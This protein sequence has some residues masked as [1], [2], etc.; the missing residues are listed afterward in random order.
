MQTQQ[1]TNSGKHPRKHYGK[2]GKRMEWDDKPD[3]VKPTEAYINSALGSSLG[4]KY[5]VSSHYRLGGWH[6]G[7]DD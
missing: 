4:H 6:I 2:F 3:N 5:T 7:M 1:Q